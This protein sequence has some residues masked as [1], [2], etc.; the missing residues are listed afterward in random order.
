MKKLIISAIIIAILVGGYFY[1]TLR[2]QPSLFISSF[3]KNLEYEGAD[4]FKMWDY[5]LSDID[6][7]PI[8]T[9]AT[10]YDEYK[11]KNNR[12]SKE[13]LFE[14]WSKVY[15]SCCI[16]YDNISVEFPQINIMSREEFAEAYKN[17]SFSNFSI[18]HKEY[19]SKILKASGY[20]EVKY[21]GSTLV[22][23]ILC[24]KQKFTL[25]ACNGS[26]GWKVTVFALYY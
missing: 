11:T 20:V 19:G 16:D 18:D 21:K 26:Q 15:L 5:L 3:C 4:S 22:N 7:T 10:Y 17:F 9:W 6:I 2:L 8:K 1:Y 12:L 14:I 13:K 25:I 24:G 23:S